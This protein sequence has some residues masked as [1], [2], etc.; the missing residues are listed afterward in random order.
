MYTLDAN[1]FLRDL[2]T[3]DPDYLECHALLAQLEATATPVIVPLVL[4]AEVAGSIR[5]EVGD[6]MRAR[7][8]V[9]LLRALPHLSFVPLDDDLADEAAA[10]AAD[11]ALC[12]MDAIYVAVAHRFG[13]TLVSLDREV[14]QRAA[15]LITVQT[16]VQALA[17][18]VP[19]RNS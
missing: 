15:P 11:Y 9:T 4:L 7:V 1:I 13:C 14:R 19:P 6:T 3:N 8:F 2:N 16:P 12:G 5:R 17:G 10:I 18:L